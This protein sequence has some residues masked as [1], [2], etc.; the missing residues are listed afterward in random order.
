MPAAL[1]L[2]TIE[3]GADLVDALV[4]LS[5]GFD[6]WI[7][8]T[9]YVESV[10]LRV[11]GEAVDQVR[12]LPGRF[13][14]LHLAGPSGGPFAV[15]LARASGAGI[16]VLGGILVHGRA[17]GVSVALHRAG[18][19]TTVPDRRPAA[20]PGVRPSS[21]ERTSAAA[22]RTAAA[23]ALAPPTWARAA[24]ASAAAA[25]RDAFEHEDETGPEAGDLVEHFAFGLCEVVTSDGDRLRIRDVKGPGRIREVSL[26]MLKTMGPFD[27][28]GRR[29]FRLV[30]RVG[31]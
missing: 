2:S 20:E 3:D 6:A 13:T 19:S 24:A 16:E 25:A 26:S 11:A 4:R 28:E 12:A 22:P 18:A 14:L 21:D 27:S 23:G 10:E 7:N 8:A 15:T 31:G 9:G 30:R 17:A 29:L 1:T 5:S